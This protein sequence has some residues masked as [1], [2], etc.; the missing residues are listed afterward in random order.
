MN[1]GIDPLLES[2]A[3]INLFPLWSDELLPLY[4]YHP[5]RRFVPAKL[6]AFTEFLA[7]LLK[8]G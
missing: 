8:T 1:L 6:K 5:S 3:L 4:V 7:A 2:G